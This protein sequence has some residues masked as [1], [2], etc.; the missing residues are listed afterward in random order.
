[1]PGVRADCLDAANRYAQVND[2]H[3]LA[4]A[5]CRRGV[6]DRILTSGQYCA[7]LTIFLIATYAYLTS[8]TSIFD[9]KMP[10]FGRW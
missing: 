2:F 6:A 8:T 10:D 7:I 9:T 1:M 3:A 4:G 5:Y